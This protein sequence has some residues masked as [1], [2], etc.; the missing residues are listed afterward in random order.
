M[1]ESSSPLQGWRTQILLLLLLVSGIGLLWWLDQRETQR[2]SEEKNARLIG[3]FTPKDVKKVQFW[4]PATEKGKE[5]NTLTIARNDSAKELANPQT[6]RWQIMTPERARTNDQAVDK[7][8][9][10]LSASY[11]QKVNDSGTDR[12]AFGLDTP[13]AV[14]TVYNEA[15]QSIQISLG[16]SA[17]ASRKRYVQIGV[18]GPVVLVPPRSVDGLMQN[19]EALRD[20]RLFANP[21]V[22]AI[23]KFSRESPNRRLELNRDK[24]LHWQMLSP[25]QDAASDTRVNSWLETLLHAQGSSFVTLQADETSALQ[26]DWLLSLHLMQDQQEKVRIQQRDNRLL[27]WRA[28]EPDAMVLE[29]HISDELEKPPLELIALRPLPQGVNPNKLE[30]TQHGKSQN[31]SKQGDEWS[32]PVWKGVEEILTR[33]AWRGVP[34]KERGEPWLQLVAV[35]EQRQW[36]IPVWKE[37]ESIILAPP[38]RK[39][40]LELTHFQAKAFV[41]TV[42]ALFPEE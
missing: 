24:D 23:Q 30:A 7:L 34:A 12:T 2:V 14:L 33:D 10:I 8:L 36:K 40:Q 27:A 3:K 16:L 29:S 21:T 20:K 38:E 11:D 42:K 31:G 17:P 39:L 32:K 13:L 4:R 1:T 41:D 9:E 5:G 19:P 15:D 28:G 35:Q 26:G 22:A 18:D 37:G 6:S 25:L